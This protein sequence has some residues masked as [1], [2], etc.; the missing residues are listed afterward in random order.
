VEAI[1]IEVIGVEA[2]VIAITSKTNSAGK[3]S[4]SK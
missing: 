2:I 3:N 1:D 4:S